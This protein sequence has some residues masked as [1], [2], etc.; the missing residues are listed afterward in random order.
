M[1]SIE[2]MTDELQ[3]FLKRAFL[4]NS[5]DYDSMDVSLI[6]TWSNSF[7][8]LYTLQQSL[9]DY[10]EIYYYSN[11]DTGKNSKQIGNLYLDKFMNACFDIDYDII[12][13]YQREEYRRSEYYFKPYTINDMIDHPE[14]FWKIPLI[15]IDNKVIWDFKMV[16]EKDCSHFILPFKRS[17]VLEN[18]RD[19]TSDEEVYK[20]HV[21]QVIVVD[22]IYYER[23]KLNKN[24]I[25]FKFIQNKFSIPKEFMSEMNVPTKKGVFFCS[26]HYPNALNND[27]ELGTTL[28]PLVDEGECLTGELTDQQ[29]IELKNYSRNFYISIVFL[30]RLFTHEFYFDGNVTIVGENGQA[31][32]FVV[33][34]D[35][36][37]PYECPVP[38][39]N[40][41]IFKKNNYSS[42]I[43]NFIMC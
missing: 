3:A 39:N 20:D 35:E 26:F 33:Q 18:F 24:Q 11:D 38:I 25:N 5:F 1:S 15:L 4:N 7:S 31:N 22:N 43:M 13:V 6:K 40:F 17:F 10:A 19:S 36:M 41:M 34:R 12:H 29:N 42:I 14:I 9:I 8:Y 28:I 2:Y 23:L 16:S 32:L 30:N 37:L 27:Y 21:I